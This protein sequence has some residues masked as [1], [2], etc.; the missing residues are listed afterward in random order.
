MDLDKQDCVLNVSLC[1]RQGGSRIR[2]MAKLSCDAAMVKACPDPR[3]GRWASEACVT[4]TVVPGPTLH[5]AS[6]SAV[7]DQQVRTH[8][9]QVLGL[10]QPPRST[11]LS[12]TGSNLYTF[13]LSGF[14]SYVMLKK[15][16][17]IS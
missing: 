6:L 3:G 2:Q 1:V 9:R 17:V 11:S 13:Q 15:W 12:D 14:C 10:L 16:P 7:E 5:L 4:L 8:I